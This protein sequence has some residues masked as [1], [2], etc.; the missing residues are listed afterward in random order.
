V[1]GSLLVAAPRHGCVLPR[2]ALGA[3]SSLVATLSKEYS[4][5]QIVAALFV[6]LQTEPYSGPKNDDSA[7][8]Y[9]GQRWVQVSDLL[10][11]QVALSEATATSGPST[12]ASGHVHSDFGS[13]V[14]DL[15]SAD[16]RWLCG[17]AMLYDLGDLYALVPRYRPWDSDNVTM[18]RLFARPLY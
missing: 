10:A 6:P 17:V 18:R 3:L 9:E 8:P 2:Q 4:L 14:V 13:W 5:Q 12:Y 7:I 1:E 15:G 16:V 11:T